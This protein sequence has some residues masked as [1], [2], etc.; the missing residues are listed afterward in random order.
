[1]TPLARDL[2]RGTP[3]SYDK[4]AAFA[5]KHGSSVW[6]QRAA[7]ALGYDDYSKARF[8]QAAN[9]FEKAK[10]DPLLRGYILFWNAQTERALHNNA[11][12]ARDFPLF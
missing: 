5:A 8:S 4:V 2:H 7:L 1:M 10:A 11:E 6:G 3:G 12:A 9:W